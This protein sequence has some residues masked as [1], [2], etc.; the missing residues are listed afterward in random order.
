KRK[1]ERIH[2]TVMNK[3]MKQGLDEL[4]KGYQELAEDPTGLCHT[5]SDH[6][7]YVREELFLTQILRKSD[8]SKQACADPENGGDSDAS[9]QACADPENGG[10]FDAFKKAFA[11]PESGGYVE[12]IEE[13]EDEVLCDTRVIYKLTDTGAFALAQVYLGIEKREHTS[14]D[15]MALDPYDPSE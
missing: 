1:A 15:S 10:Y 4:V 14:P 9:K 12:V 7:K 6:S 11:D 3:K 8:A 13:R 5:L 2:G